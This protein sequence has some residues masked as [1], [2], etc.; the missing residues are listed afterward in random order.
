MIPMS[1]RHT[2][3]QRRAAGQRG[4]K[5]VPVIVG[6]RKARL[7]VVTLTKAIEIERSCDPQRI[8]WALKKL[9]KSRKPSKILKVNSRCITLGQE[10]KRKLKLRRIKITNLT[11]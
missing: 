2:Q 11:S 1:T 5:D 6:K 8:E 9:S 10:L 4:K 7:D 3:L